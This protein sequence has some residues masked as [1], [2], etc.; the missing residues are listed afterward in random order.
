MAVAISGR[1]HVLR[2]CPNKVLLVDWRAGFFMDSWLRWPGFDGHALW[3]ELAG[4]FPPRVLATFV[5][6]AAIVTE[7]ALAVGFA[8]KKLWPFAIWFGIAYHTSLTFFMNRTFGMFW[9]AASASYLAFVRWPDDHAT[10]RFAPA[11]MAGACCD[12]STLKMRSIGNQRDIAVWGGDRPLDLP[13]W[14]A[15]GRVLVATGHLVRICGPRRPAGSCAEDFGEHRPACP[16]RS[17]RRRCPR[18]AAGANGKSAGLNASRRVT[19]NAPR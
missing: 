11:T 5:S 7:F 15:G 18:G 12:G 4:H 1:A 8:V 10:V 3:A 16:P 6:W 19:R 13:N 17:G 14:R 2:C 9:F